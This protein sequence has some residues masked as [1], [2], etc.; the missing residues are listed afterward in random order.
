MRSLRLVSW[1]S[2]DGEPLHGALLLPSSYTEGK[3]YALVVWDYGGTNRS[4]R[5]D[6]FGFEGQGPFNLQL[7]ATR[8]YAVLL[9]DAPQHLGTLMLDLLKTV[10]PCVN[11]VIEVGIAALEILGVIGTNYVG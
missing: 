8:G 10:M 9:P 11:R 7:L 3:R 1:L 5:F 6:H 2:D 4:D